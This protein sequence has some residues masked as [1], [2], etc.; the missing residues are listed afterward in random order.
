VYGL[1][2]GKHACVNLTGVS[3]LVGLRAGDFIAG[4]AAPKVASNKVVKHENA[5]CDNQHV[6]IPF[7]FD[8]FGFLTP[9]VVDLLQRVQ[10]IIQ[11]NVVSSRSMDVIFKRIDFAIQKE[12][13]RYN[14][15][16]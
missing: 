10:K 11:N 12:L 8:T 3:P 5:C 16:I 2:G 14:Y 15:Y 7:A 13:A 4:K 9:D 1:I 6:F